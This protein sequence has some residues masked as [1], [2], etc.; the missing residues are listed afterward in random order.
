MLRQDIV[1]GGVAEALLGTAVSRGCSVL[2]GMLQN[3]G[4]G[5]GGGYY[6]MLLD[7]QGLSYD[8]MFPKQ[9]PVQY[10]DGDYRRK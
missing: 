6:V 7:R 3:V 4:L 9:V 10:P 8:T 2:L 1:T 5:W